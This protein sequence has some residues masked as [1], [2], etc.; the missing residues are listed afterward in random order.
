M[1][2]THGPFYA[3]DPCLSGRQPAGC[4]AGQGVGARSWL[5]LI[6]PKNGA[7]SYSVAVGLCPSELTGT[8]GWILLRIAA[9]GK[10]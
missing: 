2:T 3:H 10:G 7:G 1:P 6:R 5:L 9:K 8:G 4:S